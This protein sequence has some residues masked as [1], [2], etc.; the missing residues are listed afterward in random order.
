M[1]E[2][3]AANSDPEAEIYFDGLSRGVILLQRCTGCDRLQFPPRVHCSRCGGRELSWK[4]VGGAGTVYAK[5]VN[6]RAP[7][8]AFEKFLPYAVALV[9][10]DAGVRVMARADCP[11]GDVVTAMRVNVFPDPDPV[12]GPGLL[13]A[14]EPSGPGG[15]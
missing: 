12:V 5:T 15:A 3:R 11:A 2:A 8:P 10:L 1:T 7:E 4:E 14:L 13:F 6:R 9:D